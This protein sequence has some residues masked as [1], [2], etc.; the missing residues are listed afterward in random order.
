MERDAFSAPKYAKDSERDLLR[1]YSTSSNS[2]LHAGMFAVQL[3]LVLSA[4]RSHW[5]PS[6]HYGG[7]WKNLDA[8]T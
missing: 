4:L 3:K 5:D 7:A 6:Q 1:L 2:S 8:G